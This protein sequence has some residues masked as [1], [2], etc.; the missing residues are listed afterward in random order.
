MLL[1]QSYKFNIKHIKGKINSCAD[2]L[3]HRLYDF[4]CTTVDMR[5]DEFP[6][7]PGYDVIAPVTRAQAKALTSAAAPALTPMHLMRRS[8]PQIKVG[9]LWT[10]RL[11]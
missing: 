11:A 6:Q 2:F 3:S 4:D 8:R 10:S 7:L 5:I 1:L 9:M